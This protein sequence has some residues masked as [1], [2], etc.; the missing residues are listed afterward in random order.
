MHINM[1]YW[2]SLSSR[3][4]SAVPCLPMI[5][6]V[7][8]MRPAIRSNLAISDLRDIDDLRQY[9]LSTDSVEGLKIGDIDGHSKTLREIVL[10][11]IDA[12]ICGPSGIAVEK[13]VLEPVEEVEVA[14]RTGITARLGAENADT[15]KPS[16]S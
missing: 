10:D 9:G 4:D 1:A 15:M 7:S 16:A 6:Y 13:P 3:V 12:F 14:V 5:S 2:P 8:S 11:R